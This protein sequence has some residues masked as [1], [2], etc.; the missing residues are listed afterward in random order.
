MPVMD[1][2]TA[3]ARIRE[4][5]RRQKRSAIPIIALTAHAIAS[6]QERIMKAGITSIV[7]KPFRKQALL[8]ELSRR[9]TVMDVQQATPALAPVHGPS[10][11]Q[12]DAGANGSA[13]QSASVVQEP[14]HEKAPVTVK[15]PA[16]G[17]MKYGPVLDRTVLAQLAE[18]TGY[19][20]M[21]ALMEILRVEMRSRAAQLRTAA[22][23]GDV[24]LLMT[25]CHALAGSAGTI[26]ATRLYKLCKQTETACIKKKDPRYLPM[27]AH[28][29]R[30]IEVLLNEIPLVSSA[31]VVVPHTER[32]LARALN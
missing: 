23:T 20:E 9:V 1:G 10:A 28:I 32:P 14:T 24:S 16:G 25:T 29:I 19:E 15:T 11:A 12:R 26:G 22:S 2:L 4:R 17:S 21:P 7:S 3:T 13:R 5:E 30:E 18:E 8:D 31:S 6:E 27:T